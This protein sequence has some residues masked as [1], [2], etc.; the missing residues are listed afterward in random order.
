MRVVSVRMSYLKTLCPSSLQKQI[1]S[2]GVDL[3]TITPLDPED[4]PES[5]LKEVES[6]FPKRQDVFYQSEPNQ[7]LR[8]DAFARLK[9]MRRRS[10]QRQYEDWTAS[11]VGIRDQE[12]IVVREDGCGEEPSLEESLAEEHRNLRDA[13][14]DYY[15][16]VV[17]ALEA[18]KAFL[19]RTYQQKAFFLY[20]LHRDENHIPKEARHLIR[21]FEAACQ[22]ITATYEDL[23]VQTLICALLQQSIFFETRGL[24]T[25]ADKCFE[26]ADAIDNLQ[27]AKEEEWIR[28]REEA[29][30][31]AHAV[32]IAEPVLHG[33]CPG[34]TVI[35]TDFE[36]EDDYKLLKTEDAEQGWNLNMHREV[37]RRAIELIE[38]RSHGRI[39]GKSSVINTSDYFRW[40]AKTKKQNT[41]QA[42]AAFVKIAPPEM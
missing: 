29:I 40:L 32:V 41:S 6:L 15:D 24:N 20:A 19:G 33:M 14:A 12:A 30:I 25:K 28:K 10:R 37:V 11:M 16:S 3:D 34:T 22:D 26:C 2:L 36:S 42:R 31:Q 17:L 23:E 38:E 21:D 39:K 7:K 13:V 8:T 9:L 18:L 4:R 5:I 27:A 1:A 35:L